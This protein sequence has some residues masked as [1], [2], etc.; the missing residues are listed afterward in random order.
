MD[1]VGTTSMV[2]LLLKKMGLGGL[3][4]AARLASGFH[5]TMRKE[6]MK[7]GGTGMRTKILN[8]GSCTQPRE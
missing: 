4:T 8:S 7:Q 6:E 2:I 5:G 3:G 1:T